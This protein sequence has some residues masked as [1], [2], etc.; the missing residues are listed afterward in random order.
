M[1]R[2]ERVTLRA[3]RRDDLQRQNAFNNDLEFEL[4]G[5]GDVPEPQSL[6]RL[7]AEFDEDAAKGGR[8]G[9]NFAIEADGQYIGRCGLFNVDE[10]A[11]TAELG[12]GIGDR[13]YWGKGYGREALRLLLTYGFDLRNLRRIW[14]TVN[15]NNE[16]AIR[17]YRAAGFKEEGRQ[18][19]HVWSNGKYVDLVYMGIS[20]EEFGANE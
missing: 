10:A 2:G 19:R 18:P 16:R 13:A 6:E 1:L 7:Q 8:D 12:I 17:S 15:G 20:R 3:M 9:A 11:R 14:L 5:G 4:L